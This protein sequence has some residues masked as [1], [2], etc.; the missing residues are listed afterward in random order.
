MLDKH[1]RH[2]RGL[3]KINGETVPGWISWEVENNTFYQADTFRVVFALSGLPGQ[4]DRRWW[5]RQR[6]VSVEILAG[7]IE[8]PYQYSAREMDSLIFGYVDEIEIDPVRGVI[9][10]CGRDLTAMLI[11][12]KN[13]EK[14]RNRTASEIATIIAN[15][16]GLT[17]VVTQTKSI[18]GTYYE[19][20]QARIQAN[21]SDWDVL[22]GEASK[23]QFVVYVT[24]KELHFEPQK[25]QQGDPYL[26]QWESPK[27]GNGWPACNVEH[28]SFRRA[29]TISKGVAVTV[30][31]WNP[32][33]KQRYEVIYPAGSTK[34]ADAVPLA[35]SPTI[36]S[37]V[38]AGLMPDQAARMAKENYMD[39]VRHE[40]EI[41]AQLPGDN[42]LKAGMQ[43]RVVGTGM[44]FDQAYL[45]DSV[46]RMMGDNDGYSM[47][48]VAKSVSDD[49]AAN[50]APPEILVAQ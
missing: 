19:I 42:R 1:V 17:P 2:P 22:C 4:F 49:L 21:I 47:T 25:S 6:A 35:Q 43:A 29:L 13:S 23:E 5:S 24:G 46:T 48:I 37:I 38:K 9:E 14:Y 26:I 27:N 20:D 39:I 40:M 30:S 11:E 12:T 32:K 34:N 7:N 16:H 15:R 41:H 44:A 3:V 33:T 50:N 31:S 36:Y 45:V 8:N 18:S 10:L 28:V